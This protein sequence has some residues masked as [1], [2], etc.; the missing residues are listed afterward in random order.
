M[1]TRFDNSKSWKSADGRVTD[2]RDMETSH[3]M[4]TI[5]MFI[6]KPHTIMSMIVKDFDQYE[7][8][9]PFSNGPWFPELNDFNRKSAKQESM[10]AVTSMSH[11][12]LI[13]YALHS[14]LVCAM[15][16]ELAARG[17]NVDNLFQMWAEEGRADEQ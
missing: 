17:V 2:I 1:N 4:N 14:L 10:H 3:I 7:D 16:D 6:R 9:Q 12:Q 15:R 5:R 11:M 13:E 8:D